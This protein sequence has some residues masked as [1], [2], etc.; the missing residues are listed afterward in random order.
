MKHTITLNQYSDKIYNLTLSHFSHTSCTFELREDE[1]KNLGLDLLAALP[2]SVID[3]EAK[4]QQLVR[5]LPL[6]QPE[7]PT[8]HEPT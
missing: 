2:Q 4:R 1:V 3:N 5:T 7:E 6:L 8:P